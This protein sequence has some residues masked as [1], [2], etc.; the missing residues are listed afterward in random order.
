MGA[1]LASA[2]RERGRRDTEPP[3]EVAAV[4]RSF[5][6]IDEDHFPFV[7]RTLRMLGVRQAALED[8]AQTPS[9]WWRDSSAH[10][11][12]APPTISRQLFLL[13]DAEENR[14]LAGQPITVVELSDGTVQ[15]RHAGLA[16]A[17]APRCARRHAVAFERPWMPAV[18]KRRQ[19]AR[20]TT[21]APWSP[22]GVCTPAPAR[23]CGSRFWPS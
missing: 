6:T 7:W 16:T 10:L 15:A 4:A 9:A 12:V 17:A 11:M 13:P 5:D 2:E 23:R 18:P 20:P 1:K 19:R 22:T 14:L 8:A 3:L 21:S